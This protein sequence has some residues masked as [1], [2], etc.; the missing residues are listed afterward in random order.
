MYDRKNADVDGSREFPAA[1]LFRQ[2][3]RLIQTTKKDDH[4][5]HPLTS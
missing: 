2:T 4:S 1:L 3:G 5:D